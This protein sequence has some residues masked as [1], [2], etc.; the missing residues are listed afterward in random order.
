M[1]SAETLHLFQAFGVELEYMIVDAKS[2]DVRPIT[3][4]VLEA[5]AGK[6]TSDFVDGEITW[7]NELTAHVIELKTTEPMATLR[8][9]IELESLKIGIVML[10]LGAMHFFNIFIFAKMRRRA[11]TG[12]LPPRYPA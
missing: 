5:V 7:S 4:R 12:V 10:I 8:E 2:L 11:T 6:I 1:S 9:A 3:D